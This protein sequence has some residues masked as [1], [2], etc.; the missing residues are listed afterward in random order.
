MSVHQEELKKVSSFDM[1]GARDG[2]NRVSFFKVFDWWIHC[3]KIHDSP[4]FPTP[5][6][7]L[8]DKWSHDEFFS[9]IVQWFP[10]LISRW[11]KSTWPMWSSCGSC[12]KPAKPPLNVWWRTATKSHKNRSG[13]AAIF[14]FGK[15]H[16]EKLPR[17][18]R[19]AKVSLRHI[20]L[21]SIRR[22]R[23]NFRV[24][25]PW[26]QWSTDVARWRRPPP[27]NIRQLSM[28]C[29]RWAV[30]E[31]EV[32][33]RALFLY[34]SSFL[35]ICWFNSP[36]FWRIIISWFLLVPK[37]RIRWVKIDIFPWTVVVDVSEVRSVRFPTR[38]V[39]CVQ[40]NL[41]DVSSKLVQSK[42][43]LER[44]KHRDRWL[45]LRFLRFRPIWWPACKPWW[46]DL[47]VFLSISFCMKRNLHDPFVTVFGQDRRLI[48]MLLPAA[49]PL[50]GGL[51]R[52]WRSRSN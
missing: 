28:T 46:S 22:Y 41:D 34:F 2:E 13:F 39:S 42:V 21:R 9:E 50:L 17:S 12:R 8:C 52:P 36:F 14:S 18:W 5:D 11:M 1:A 19:A 43:D 26:N 35:L 37:W 15:C 32:I 44:P 27:A 30:L 38:C 4:H 25:S 40:G 16:G 7:N 6:S 24:V 51:C 49:W 20:V 31:K 23:C 47:F 10:R 29:C 33:H 45:A 48:Y 3:F